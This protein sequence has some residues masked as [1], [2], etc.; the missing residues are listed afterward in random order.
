VRGEKGEEMRGK[1]RCVQEEREG[2]GI[3]R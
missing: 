1:E 2:T 3:E